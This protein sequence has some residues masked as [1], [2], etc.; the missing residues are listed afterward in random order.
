MYTILST[1]LLILLM[2]GMQLPLRS[3]LS[4]DDGFFV[5]P[6]DEFYDPSDYDAESSL[7]SGANTSEK[8]RS[9]HTLP[10]ENTDITIG[11]QNLSDFNFAIVGDWG[12]TKNTAKTVELIQNHDPD[13]VFSLGDTSYGPDINCWTDIVSPISYKIKAVIGN[14]DVMSPNLLEQHLKEFGL[15][16]PYYSFDYNNIH[17]LMMDS[18]SSYLPGSDPDFSNLEDT[19][20]YQFVEN[21][22]AK[23]SI[24]PYINW[25]IVMS[26]RQFYSS[27]C[28]EHDSC[29]PIK[30]LRES[31]HPLFEKYGVDL[32]F[33]GHAH[34][35]ERTYPL[36]YNDINSSQPIIEENGK[37]EYK[38]SNGMFQL[39]V[40]TGGI[41]FDSFSNQEPYVV[42][43]QDSS[44][45]FLN[46]DIVGQGNTLVGKYYTNNGDISD[47]FKINK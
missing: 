36:F 24:N 6:E 13:I 7:P 9:E 26:H 16:K 34:N 12:C 5:V 42:S 3:T 37:T 18:E 45:G 14:H 31:Y 46:I 38:S 1:T 8:F 29:E 47:E 28:G 21:D 10:N 23:A 40:G 19:E 32:L 41:D 11:S 20:Q 33:S 39:I 15:D 25:I 27:L 22:L 4:V 17:F 44:Y 2:L 35:Y 30:K 43:Q